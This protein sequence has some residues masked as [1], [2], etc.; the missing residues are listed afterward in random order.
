LKRTLR[1]EQQ[2]A[3]LSRLRQPLERF[4]A[5]YPG[6]PTGR[7]AVHTVYG[8]AHLFRAETAQRL[9][10]L[11]L[12]SLERYAP[13]AEIFGQAL[14]LKPQLA[15]AVYQRVVR[16]LKREA[17]EDFRID[18]ED[19]FGH[20]PDEEEDACAAEAAR[21][22]AAGLEAGTL[23]PFVG[24]RIKS[25]SRELAPRAARTLDLFLTQLLA[26]SGGRLP[27]G[28]VVTVPKLVV[29]EQ[30]AAVADL[31]DAFEAEAGL[32]SGALKLELMVETP[33][34]LFDLH[35]RAALPPLVAA[36]RGRCVAAHFG[37]YD[38]TASLNITAEHQTMDHGACDIA[39]NLMQLTLAGTG[40]FLSDG[41]TNVLP[42]APHRA[43]AGGALSSEQVEEN[44]Q[45]VHRAW[46]LH[47]DHVRHSLENA[48]YQG[49]DLH[50]AQLPTRYGALYSFFLE[51]LE[52]ASRRLTNFIEQAAQ[53]TLV[54]DVFDDA[55]TGQGL[56][57]FFLRGINCGAL[58][59]EE[60]L[61]TGITLEE[62]RG[63]S[64]LRILENRRV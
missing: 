58:A 28:F 16:K 6:D 22:L 24:I 34:S 39:R 9:G 56:L 53:A 55:A 10:Q 11:A 50:P 31:F 57:N 47:F 5:A 7:Q 23:P 36:A 20:R 42:V 59:E 45:T 12:V 1:D 30:V 60:A 54:G 27:S 8:G 29:A 17:V 21:Q 25:L 52:A 41:A 40:V 37:V 32:E 38:Y 26:A 33:Q 19:G 35:G 14:G 13:T 48:I 51:S 18:F 64:F 4:A 43:A 15:E 2:A 46:R 61:A 44:R 63:R 62:L 49:W 3:I